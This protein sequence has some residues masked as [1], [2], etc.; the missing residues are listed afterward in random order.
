MKHDRVEAETVEKG[1]RERE[2][3][4]LVGEDGTSDPRSQPLRPY[5]VI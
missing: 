2:V 4:H 5:L 3:L 1:K